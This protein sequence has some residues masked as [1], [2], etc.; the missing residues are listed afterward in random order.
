V[1]TSTDGSNFSTAVSSATYTFTSPTNV[2]NITTP[3]TNARYVR[4]NITA[5]SGWSAGQASEF[6]VYP[7]G[8]GTPPTSATL[9]ANPS[10]LDRYRGRLTP[11]SS[12]GSEES[13]HVRVEPIGRQLEDLSSG[14]PGDA[15]ELGLVVPVDVGFGHVKEEPQ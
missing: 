6:E 5:N 8:G 14:K 4:V 3:A 1:Q 2:V 15:A 13:V 7:S 12:D 9:N 11:A 10:S